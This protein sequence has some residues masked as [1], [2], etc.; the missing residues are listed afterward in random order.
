MNVVHMHSNL[1]D[2]RCVAK[3]HQMSISNIRVM[4]GVI[5]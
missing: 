1:N 3:E 5:L 4:L 2:G